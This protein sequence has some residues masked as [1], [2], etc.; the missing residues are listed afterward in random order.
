MFKLQKD[1]VIK[2]VDSSLKRDKLLNMGFAL[3]QTPVDLPEEENDVSYEKM[4]FFELQK[5]AKEAGISVYRQKKEDLIK[6][7]KGLKAG[8]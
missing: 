6:A 7:L 3:V 8:E 1:N 4:D 2:I 5:I